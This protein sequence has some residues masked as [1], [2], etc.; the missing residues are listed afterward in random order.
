MTFDLVHA[1][2][3][4]N[5]FGMPMLSIYQYLVAW[6]L[7]QS[8]L[9]IATAIYPKDLFAEDYLTYWNTSASLETH[10]ESEIVAGQMVIVRFIAS[11]S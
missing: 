7:L 1:T 3:K 9:P 6:H 4:S 5:P 2:T 10:V 8:C 11:T